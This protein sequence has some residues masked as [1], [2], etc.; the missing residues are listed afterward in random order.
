MIWK[1]N[2]TDMGYTHWVDGRATGYLGITG[3]V[4]R[5][6]M[7]GITIIT[8]LPLA[9]TPMWWP[10]ITESDVLN[11][12]IKLNISSGSIF[13]LLILSC[14]F[15]F[16]TLFFYVRKRTARSLS[17]KHLLHKFSH[18]TRDSIDALMQRVENNTLQQK[19][20]IAHEQAQFNNYSK[21]V[22]NTIAK[23]FSEI[24]KDKTVGCAIRLLVEEEGKRVYRTA[25]RSDVFSPN[26]EKTTEDINCDESVAGFFTDEKI[27]QT[28]VLFI[29]DFEKAEDA[30]VFKRT[31]NCK[32][33]SFDMTSLAVVPINGWYGG[34]TDLIGLLCISCQS[35]KLLKPVNVDLFRFTADTLAFAISSKLAQIKMLTESIDNVTELQN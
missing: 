3:F 1:N 29:H 34:K 28:G 4:L 22:C 5:L 10:M 13:T 25:G 9:G 31:K 27:N 17:I 6:R 33:Y 15:I 26:R 16:T 24:S 35:K 11:Q 12:T 32:Q 20:I 2:K 14:F 21:A 19:E 8:G 18:E 23:Y 7:L 30:K